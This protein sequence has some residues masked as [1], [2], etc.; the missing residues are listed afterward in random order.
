MD[1]N[2]DP[3]LM[4]VDLDSM[5]EAGLRKALFLEVNIRVPRGPVDFMSEEWTEPA[6]K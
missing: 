2:M 4:K 6:A 5:Y 1:G 3:E